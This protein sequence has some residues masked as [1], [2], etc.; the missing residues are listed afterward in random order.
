MQQQEPDDLGRVLAEANTAVDAITASVSDALGRMQAGGMADLGPMLAHANEVIDGITASLAKAMSQAEPTPPVTPAPFGTP[1]TGGQPPVAPIPAFDTSGV[2][3][4]PAVPAGEQANPS[5]PVPEKA[6]ET[7]QLV[8]EA[9]GETVARALELAEAVPT[10]NLE[11]EDAADGIDLQMAPKGAKQEL[12]ADLL[13]KDAKGAKASGNAEGAA[14]RE[15]PERQSGWLA[16]L[17]QAAATATQAMGSGLATV[18]SAVA[19][20]MTG[21][22]GG[23]QQALGAFQA[24]TGAAAGWVAVFNPQIVRVFQESLDS[25]AATIGRSLAPIVTV[26]TGVVREFTA[27]MAPV[28]RQLEPVISGLAQTFATV[29]RPIID[30]VAATAQALMPI[31][32]PLMD[33]VQA[34]GIGFHTVVG[35]LGAVVTS[36]AQ[37][38]G[39]LAGGEELKSWSEALVD[40]ME[41]L[42]AGVVLLIGTFAKWMKMDGLVDNLIKTFSP[43]ES[44][45]E[46]GSGEKKAPGTAN[47]VNLEAYGKSVSAAAFGALGKDEQKEEKSPSEYM[48]E[49]ID[50]LR[51]LQDGTKSVED[52]LKKME[53]TITKAISDGFDQIA[54]KVF[55]AAGSAAGAIGS[56]AYGLYD[57]TLGAAGR[58]LGREVSIGLGYGDPG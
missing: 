35:V 13:A 32:R 43:G 42:A 49:T 25:L 1:A 44:M 51:G 14:D 8:A 56:G 58:R 12:P 7:F 3:G 24:V 28:F 23:L 9:L 57:S 37:W 4:V 20:G 17:G 54:P 29:L 21:L 26:M 11:L 27:K 48:Q 45:A 53:A 31:L 41:R 34:V 52:V 33:V 46:E 30:A 39:N 36:F 6:A 18:T 15:Q 16:A 47:F 50:E 22:A 10:L 38:L 55:G 5:P 19:T 40:L 2:Q